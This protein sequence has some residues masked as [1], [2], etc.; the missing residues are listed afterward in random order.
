MAS[1]KDA[2]IPSNL[3]G[4][5]S[6]ECGI[7]I[8]RD[9]S[10]DDEELYEEKMIEE[11]MCEEQYLKTALKFFI[12]AYTKNWKFLP[13]FKDPLEPR[14]IADSMLYAGQI[15]AKLKDENTNRYEKVE[16]CFKNIANV[17]GLPDWYPKYQPLLFLYLFPKK[18]CLDSV[19]DKSEKPTAEPVVWD[20]FRKEIAGKKPED[21][22]L[23]ANKWIFYCLKYLDE[24][25]A[26]EKTVK[27]KTVEEK[28]VETVEDSVPLKMIAEMLDNPLKVCSREG[29]R[30]NALCLWGFVLHKFVKCEDDAVMFYEKSR[31]LRSVVKNSS[32]MAALCINVI[33]EGQIE[34][35]NDIVL[36]EPNK[37]V[38]NIINESEL[39]DVVNLINRGLD[40]IVKSPVKQDQQEQQE[41]KQNGKLDEYINSLKEEVPGILKKLPEPIKDIL[42]RPI[43]QPEPFEGILEKH[44][45]NILYRSTGVSDVNPELLSRVAEVFVGAFRSKFDQIKEILW[46]FRR[47]FLKQANLQNQLR[48]NQS[49]LAELHSSYD[50]RTVIQELEMIVGYSA[51]DSPT[52]HL[53]YLYQPDTFSYSDFKFRIDVLEQK[54][55]TECYH[56]LNLYK[57]Y[58]Y[59][60]I[61]LFYRKLSDEDKS[62]SNNMYVN[63]IILCLCKALR[64]DP[65]ADDSKHIDP[66]FCEMSKKDLEAANRAVM[67]KILERTLNELV[68]QI[69]KLFPS[70]SSSALSASNQEESK[71]AAEK[72]NEDK[73]EPGFFFK[74]LC[75]LF[76]PRLWWSSVW[77]TNLNFQEKNNDDP[78]GPSE[79]ELKIEKGKIG[80]EALGMLNDFI[81][82]KSEIKFSRNYVQRFCNDYRFYVSRDKLLALRDGHDRFL[83]G[84]NTTL[85]IAAITAY[86]IYSGTFK[87][88]QPLF[89]CFI[90]ELW[91][92]LGLSILEPATNF[93]LHDWMT[94]S[95]ATNL[96]LFKSFLERQNKSFYSLTDKYTNTEGYDYSALY[97][98]YK[99]NKSWI[100]GAFQDLK[101]KVYGKLFDS[102]EAKYGVIVAN[103]LLSSHVY[104]R[105]FNIESSYEEFQ[106]KYVEAL[107]DAIEAVQK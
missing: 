9:K 18:F 73:N 32:C 100:D 5:E 31:D 14:Y 52:F 69:Q 96:T 21:L 6:Y 1:P 98:T 44:I 3:T 34:D 106:L 10:E 83:Y 84:L 93:V 107:N 41:Q 56:V 35:I 59:L 95:N 60:L 55:F 37:E 68:L 75:V 19:A 86:P 13:S 94:T 92:F 72:K 87:L 17:P 27:E 67:Q 91:A 15:T 38:D 16:E 103:Q 24:K 48:L 101:E 80:D 25:T 97:N 45:Y 66:T 22:I 23:V 88:T 53:K 61:A 76:Q 40:D 81:G 46:P 74:R 58:A 4:K 11:K 65:E 2:E 28:T 63:K 29:M 20:T 82:K 85:N 54:L 33:L 71:A 89:V 30:A 104:T 70:E 42:E 43:K 51:F 77:E 39:L 90:N 36:K 78:L 47:I 49:R 79:E 26:E 105:E 62:G 99:T 12:D 64:F 7:A 102:D 8:Y 50:Y 57:S